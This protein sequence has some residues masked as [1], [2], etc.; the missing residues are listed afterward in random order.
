M[1][2]YKKNQL[3]EK[4]SVSGSLDERIKVLSGSG[5]FELI[6]SVVIGLLL[7]VSVNVYFSANGYIEAFSDVENI[8]GL[9]FGGIVTI[10]VAFYIGRGMK[11]HIKK[12]YLG[13]IQLSEAIEVTGGK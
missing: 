12:N 7:I 9:I 6:T 11:K 2:L 8:W 4:F 10:G 3:N 1:V 13:K 5:K